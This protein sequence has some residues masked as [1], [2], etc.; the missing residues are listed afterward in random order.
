GGVSGRRGTAKRGESGAD[1]RGAAGGAGREQC[2]GGVGAEGGGRFLGLDLGDRLAPR[3]RRP[4]RGDPAGQGYEIVIRSEAWCAQDPDIVG[5][6][7]LLRRPSAT[8]ESISPCL[9]PACVRSRYA[10]RRSRWR[11]LCTTTDAW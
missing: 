11:R 5:Q 1:G 7:P 3:H 9:R 10:S 6:K 4:V 8:A 2:A